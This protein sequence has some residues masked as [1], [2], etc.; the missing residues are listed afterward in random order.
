MLSSSNHAWY[1]LDYLLDTLLTLYKNITYKEE[2]VL[3]VRY[4]SFTHVERFTF[5]RGRRHDE[6]QSHLKDDGIHPGVRQ[7]AA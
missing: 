7:E 4:S 2:G 1:C 5:R 6:S 3:N